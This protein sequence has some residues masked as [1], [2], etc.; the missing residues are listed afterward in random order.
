MDIESVTWMCNNT[1]ICVWI[2]VYLFHIMLALLYAKCDVV[3]GFWGNCSVG[4]SWVKAVQLS[5]GTTQTGYQK[6][7]SWLAEFQDIRF[8]NIV[9]VVGQW[10]ICEYLM[11]F[12]NIVTAPC[13]GHQMRNHTETNTG[14][15]SLLVSQMTL[16]YSTPT[17]NSNAIGY[18]R[19]L[20]SSCRL[21]V[22]I[23]HKHC[24]ITGGDCF[25][26]VC[27]FTFYCDVWPPAKL[28]IIIKKINQDICPECLTSSQEL[29]RVAPCT[30]DPHALVVE[31]FEI[32]K[33]VQSWNWTA[34]LFIVR[35]VPQDT[36][37]WWNLVIGTVTVK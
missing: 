22:T 28:N 25:V 23:N 1:V 26:F 15:T 29:P 7:I 16:E 30:A 10:N 18:C 8:P 5:K 33:Y 35:Q 14:G 9:P 19:C 11:L 6:I 13:Q 20:A 31:H 34:L 27:L 21:Y 17:F 12:G 3:S 2:T 4:S 32:V 36:I 24:F 37:N